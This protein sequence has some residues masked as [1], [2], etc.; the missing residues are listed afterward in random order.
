MKGLVIKKIKQQKFTGDADLLRK[1]GKD[2]KL[3]CGEDGGFISGRR[4]QQDAEAG[5]EVERFA[6]GISVAPFDAVTEL[7]DA[8]NHRHRVGWRGEHVTSDQF[9]AGRSAVEALKS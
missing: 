8:R 2:G 9:E 5:L 1:N 6:A 7:K 3:R 4:G